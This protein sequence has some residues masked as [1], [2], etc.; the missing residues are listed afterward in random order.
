M[1]VCVAVLE[2]VGLE[3]G[4]LQVWWV[5]RLAIDG[6]NELNRVDL[7]PINTQLLVF[8]A[9]GVVCESV[10]DH[11]GLKIVSILTSETE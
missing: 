3:V 4:K 8:F 11:S 6:R 7:A 10:C 9:T 5:D 1:L 2:K